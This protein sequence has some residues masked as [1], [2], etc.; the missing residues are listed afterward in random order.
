M[1]A[2]RACMAAWPRA[3]MA[4]SRSTYISAVQRASGHGFIAED[5]PRQCQRCL[6]KRQQ[7]ASV[8]RPGTYPSLRQ[9]RRPER[10]PSFHQYRSP[11]RDHVLCKTRRSRICTRVGRSSSTDPSVVA[12]TPMAETLHL[13]AGSRT[14]GAWYQSE[15]AERTAGKNMRQYSISLVAAYSTSVVALKSL[16]GAYWT[17]AYSEIKWKARTVSTREEVSHLAS[18]DV[19]GKQKSERSLPFF[20][21]FSPLPPPPALFV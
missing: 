4:V 13:G 21:D 16:V 3:I 2:V 15:A 5:R 8:Q 19:A 9:Y 20:G 1:E 17:R 12:M 6:H 7:Q 18:D 11:G 10:Y 14:A